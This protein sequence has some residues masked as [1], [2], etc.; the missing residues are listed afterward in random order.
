MACNRDIFTFI[1]TF[2]HKAVGLVGP[3]TGLY[4]VGR[5]DILSLLA[6]GRLARSQS[7]C[8]LS[9]SGS[10]NIDIPAMFAFWSL[11]KT[12]Y[13]KGGGEG[14]KIAAIEGFQAG[15]VLPFGKGR[16]NKRSKEAKME[17]A[18]FFMQIAGQSI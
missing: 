1:F 15:P 10:L 13:F 16:F 8:C 18:L 7:L 4:D 3:R 2:T 11:W 17:S 14:I 5:R 12:L 9:Y 6:L